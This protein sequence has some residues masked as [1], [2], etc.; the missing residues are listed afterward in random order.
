MKAIYWVIG[1]LAGAPLLLV[2][3]LF[4][5]SEL[6]GEVVTLERPEPD[7]DVSR[8]RVWIVDKNGTS[9]V[10]HGDAQS[11]WIAQLADSPEVVLTR[12]G[13]TVTYIGTP[14]P[15]AHDLYHQ[16]RRHKYGWADRLIGLFGGGEANCP[17]VP[18]RLQ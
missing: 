10:E 7:G 18:V 1:I 16:L 3:T 14:D 17:G 12:N 13:Q 2:V 11:Y 15:N 9:W 8:I 5:A 4:G 6:G